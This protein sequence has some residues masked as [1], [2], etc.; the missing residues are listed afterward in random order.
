MAI[1]KNR[2]SRC[3]LKK[4]FV[5]RPFQSLAYHDRTLSL[6][7][8]FIT[9]E[10]VSTHQRI[11][12]FLVVEIYRTKNHLNPCFMKEISRRE[13]NITTEDLRAM[14]NDLGP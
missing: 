4:A 1:L 6:E 10:P 5:I 9:E 13:K 7:E 11:L 3:Y 12:R 8:L 14:H 2:R